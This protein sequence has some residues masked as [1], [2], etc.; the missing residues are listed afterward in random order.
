L[1][2]LEHD[3]YGTFYRV[4]GKLAGPNGVNLSVT[5]IWLKPRI[6]GKFQFVPGKR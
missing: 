4:A 2:I 1:G 6:D 5:T 3:S